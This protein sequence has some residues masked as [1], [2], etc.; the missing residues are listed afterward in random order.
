MKVVLLA[1][2]MG[3]RL[4]EETIV[5]P[6]PM[7]EIGGMPILLHIMHIYYAWGHRDFWV[8]CGFKGEFIKEYFCNFNLRHS[9]WSITLR[10]GTFREL[11][12]HVPDWNVSLIDTGVNTMTGGR[13]GRLQE[14]VGGGTFMATYGDGVADVN[15]SE[16]LEFHR[17]H[18]K[19]AT[20]TAVH[21][22]ARFGCMEISDGRVTSF[23]EKPQVTEGWINGGFFVF[24]PEIF[25][26]LGGDDTILEREPMERL[27]ADGELMA[28]HHHGFWQPMDTLREK[29]MLESMW[30]AGKAPWRI[31]DERQDLT[32][33]I[34]RQK[35]AGHGPHRIQGSVAGHMAEEDG[36]DRRR[37]GKAS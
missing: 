31:W 26:Y 22:P 35:R 11:R 12:S 16:L 25:D 7:V 29:Q 28:Y 23:A 32:S 24:E 13:I 2:G 30:Q 21:P 5:R 8:A 27:A 3:T 6:K 33:H 34:S 18:G 10:D 19:I 14:S 15:L 17:A 1:G 36:S 4:V 37:L 20:V 9:D